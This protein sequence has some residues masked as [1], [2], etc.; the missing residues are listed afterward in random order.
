MG[1]RRSIPHSRNA[2]W[3]M[4]RHGDGSG[5]LMNV[6][7]LEL[8]AALALAPLAAGAAD[9]EGKALR[10]APKEAIDTTL[11]AREV[12]EEPKPPVITP[13]P[14]RRTQMSP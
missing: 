8:A 4:S 7:I 2:A 10:L 14:G 5:S 9:A 3:R 12:I 6:L 13:T 1:W 11:P